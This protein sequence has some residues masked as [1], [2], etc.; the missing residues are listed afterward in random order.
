MRTIAQQWEEFSRLVFTNGA[1]DIQ[2]QEMRRAF[3]AGFQGAMNVLTG[4]AAE[5]DEM[6]DEAAQGIFTG[7]QDECQAFAQDIAAGRA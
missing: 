7:L 4:M 1:P 6:S 3:Y 2:R 5:E